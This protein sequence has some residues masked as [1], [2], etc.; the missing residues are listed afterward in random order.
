MII[1]NFL[2]YSKSFF[3]LETFTFSCFPKRNGRWRF[4]LSNY[5][6][7]MQLDPELFVLKSN[8]FRLP[9]PS[10]KRRNRF[11]LEFFFFFSLVLGVKLVPNGVLQLASYDRMLLGTPLLLCVKLDTVS[12]FSAFSRFHFE[13]VCFY[14]FYFFFLSYFYL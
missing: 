5:I 14:R 10:H 9:S 3:S 6:N 11:K 13:H 1:F 8:S 7:F 12:D 2:F 4:I